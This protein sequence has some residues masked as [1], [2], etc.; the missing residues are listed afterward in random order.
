MPEKSPGEDGVYRPGQGQGDLEQGRLVDHLTD[1]V[2]A[3]DRADNVRGALH[4]PGGHEGGQG[5]HRHRAGPP[6]P[7]RGRVRGRLAT[8]QK[9]PGDQKKYQ[10]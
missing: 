7:F 4:L 8:E 6:G 5:Q 10:G 2:L 3:G 9:K 1:V